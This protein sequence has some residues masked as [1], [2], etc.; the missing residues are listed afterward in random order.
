MEEQLDL[1][2][3]IE[4]INLIREDKLSKS[5]FLSMLPD[6]LTVLGV[7]KNI[8]SIFDINLAPILENIDETNK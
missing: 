5:D 1:K 4:V 3:D 8:Q 2:P 6:Y 7:N